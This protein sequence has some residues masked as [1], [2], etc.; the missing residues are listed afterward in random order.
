MYGIPKKENFSFLC[1]S[2][3]IKVK[4]DRVVE[5]RKN[6][7]YI[8]IF[9]DSERQLHI[10]GGYKINGFS[11]K[12]EKATIND[13]IGK[14]INNV[15][16]KSDFEMVIDFDYGINLHLFDDEPNFECI[17]FYPENIII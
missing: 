10:E 6:N 8:L 15:Q 5:K 4:L 17:H 11:E 7:H 13:L 2:T 16:I 14:T 1:G 9:L 12:G 3:V